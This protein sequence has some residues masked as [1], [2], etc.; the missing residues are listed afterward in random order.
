MTEPFIVTEASTW[1]ARGRTPEHAEALAQA[2][3][4]FPDLQP[5]AP[6]ADRMERMR[7]RVAAMRPVNDAISE[8]TARDREAANFAFTTRR[9]DAGAHD[10]RDIAILHARDTYGYRWLAAVRYS[11]GRLAAEAGWTRR[12]VLDEP[13][14]YARGFADGGGDEADIFDA[15]R[16]SF[17]AARDAAALKEDAAAGRPLPSTWPKPSDQHRPASWPR[18]LLI[19]AE[20]P[21]SSLAL[22]AQV[23]IGAVVVLTS[24]R[25]FVPL[26]DL[27]N[28]VAEAMTP[29]QADA[30]AVDPT[31]HA[32][33]LATLAGREVDDVLVAADGEY[34]RVIDAHARALPLCRTMERTRNTP[35]QQRQHL[36][37]WLARGFAP[38]E[39]LGA[40][41]IRW[42]KR[43]QGFAASLGEFKARVDPSHTGRGARILITT[44]GGL[45]ATGFATSAGAILDPEVQVTSKARL[46]AEMERA[47]RAFG[48]ATRLIGAN[49]VLV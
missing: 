18:R 42:S 43:A 40:G 29:A 1:I 11:E 21:A 33:L 39:N 12:N 45:P 5:S 47:L 15:A 27:G 28:D 37:L 25:G 16:R 26:A 22:L 36:R 46:K 6:L 19:I 9:I 49:Q 24:S 2:W 30:L 17:A 10:A 32:S 23:P 14:A 4:D 35:L 13:E 7:Q 20:Q 44:E 34:L 38:G 8:Q 48:A 31:Q 41:H 3:R